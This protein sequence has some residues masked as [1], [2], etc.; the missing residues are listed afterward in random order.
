MNLLQ[1]LLEI[2]Q[3]VD[4]FVKDKK[5]FN[6]EY[7]TGDQVLHKI[8]P[9]M[10]KHKILLKQEIISI[11]NTPVTYQTKNAEKMEILTSTI[12]KFTWI[13]S[14]SGEREEVQFAG[15]GF[16]D[17]DKG[18]GSALTYAERY[19][20]LKFFHVPTDKDD[21]DARQGYN[22]GAA[23]KQFKGKEKEW[24]NKNTENFEAAKK[25]IK[26]GGFTIADIRKKYKVSKEVEQLLTA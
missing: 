15:N 19:F 7:V 18:L 26:E 14:E 22:E 4:A 16:N 3:E 17:F 21:P 23:K 24:L 9:L 2:Q 13:D 20:L 1:K 8:R 10:N 6:Y 25:A 12:Q 5:G 11:E